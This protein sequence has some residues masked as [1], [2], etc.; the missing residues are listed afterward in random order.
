M[1]SYQNMYDYGQD[2]VYD[3]LQAASDD[4]AINEGTYN[5]SIDNAF[6]LGVKNKLE[7]AQ[8]EGSITDSQVKTHEAENAYE[9]VK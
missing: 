7:D 5:S 8:V 1:G 2:H 4:T 6:D 3:Q 9:E